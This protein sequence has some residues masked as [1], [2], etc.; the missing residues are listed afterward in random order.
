MI[1]ACSCAARSA[2]PG[3]PGSRRGARRRTAD[4][5]ADR[6]GPVGLVV[7]PG[8]E[9][10]QEDPLR[11]L[12]EGH[13]DG[14]HPAP[15]VVAEADAVDLL[16]VARD[17][18]LGADPRVDAVLDRVLLGGQPEGVEADRV[19]HLVAGHHLVAAQ[20]VGRDV[21]QRV[22]D[23]Q[24]G[25]GGVRE[26]VQDVGLGLRVS[27]GQSGTSKVWCGA[28]YS[29]HLGS[30]S[31]ATEAVYRNLGSSLAGLGCVVCSLIVVSVLKIRLVRI[32][33]GS[34]MKVRAGNEKAPRA[35]RGAAL[36]GA[37]GGPVLFQRGELRSSVTARM[38]QGYQRRPGDIRPTCGPVPG[39][40]GSAQGGT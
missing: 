27:A 1:V 32:T 31:A 4:Q 24:A 15:G 3:R 13:V 37:L 19:Q 6:P 17:V 28:Q 29:C 18:A 38:P 21:A 23:V 10:L 20:H 34:V 2:R 33:S 39:P 25:A 11:P 12:V 8:V 30:I 9:D 5:H 40:A 26:H 36:T 35:W 22:A 16:L 7:V 14:R